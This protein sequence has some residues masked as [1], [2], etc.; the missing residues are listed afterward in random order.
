MKIRNAYT[1]GKDKPTIDT[2]DTLTEQ[3][4]KAETDMNYILREYS[5]T[6]FIK[7]SK[8]NQG[9]YDDVTVTDFT[10]ALILVTNSQRM[11]NEL[12]APVRSRFQN[13]PGKFLEFVQDKNNLQEM[14]KLGILKGNDGIDIKG[15]Q[16]NVPTPELYEEFLKERREKASEEETKN[17]PA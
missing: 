7:H 1:R 16:T 17:A 9:R 15:T 6:G 13:D 12:P 2:G 4:H 3:S 10:E 8:E 11:F 14:H 5:R